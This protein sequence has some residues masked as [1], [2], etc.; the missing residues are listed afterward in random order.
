VLIFAHDDIH[1]CDF[2]WPA[3]ILAGLAQYDIVGLAGNRRRLPRQPGWYFVDETMKGDHDENLSGVVAHGDGFPPKRMDIYGAAGQEVKLLDGL[4]LAAHSD[5]LNSHNL[6]FDE[7][8]EFH[9]Y[10]LDFCRQAEQKNL[11]MGTIPLSV[12]HESRG[13]F[14]SEAWKDGFNKYL[15]KWKT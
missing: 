5:T 10:D 2:F 9:H 6:F 7:Q 11:R 15:G 14:S 12:I 13:G 1:I 4:L 3:T 8:F